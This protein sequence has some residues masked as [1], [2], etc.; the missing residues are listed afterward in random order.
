[1][2]KYVPWKEKTWKQ[3]KKLFRAGTFVFLFFVVL[4]FFSTPQLKQED[5]DY[6]IVELTKSPKFEKQW[7]KNGGTNYWLVLNTKTATYK[8]TGID[9]KYLRHR[10]FKMNIKRGDTLKVGI[11]EGK[12]FTLNKDYREYLQFEKAQFHKSQ[13]R[14]FSRY[15]FST[16]SILCLIPLFFKK[17]PTISVDGDDTIVDFGVLLGVGLILCFLILLATI[18]YNFISGSEF[19]E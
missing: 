11:N 17:Q 10:L 1:M 2:P 6:K 9:Y 5:L 14:I 12:V 15:L 7:T 3:K 19:V 16:G 4:T 13:N 18:G 8:I